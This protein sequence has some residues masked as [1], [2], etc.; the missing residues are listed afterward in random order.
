MHELDKDSCIFFNLLGGFPV[1]HSDDSSM[2]RWK[3]MEDG[4]LGDQVGQKVD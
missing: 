3:R 4:E 1:G 2:T